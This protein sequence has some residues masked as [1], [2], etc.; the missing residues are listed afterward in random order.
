MSTS[1]DDAKVDKNC[2]F[3]RPVYKKVKKE[4]VF[5]RKRLSLWGRDYLCGKKRSEDLVKTLIPHV[6]AL[7]KWERDS[8]WMGYY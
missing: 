2:D 7:M 6:E 3:L 8:Y 1:D 5:V 4:T